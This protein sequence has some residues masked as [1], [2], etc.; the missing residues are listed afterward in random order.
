MSG[1]ESARD[2]RAG[3]VEIQHSK[4]VVALGNSA[5]LDKF[6]SVANTVLAVL[7]AL[8]VHF[9]VLS[10]EIL[11]LGILLRPLDDA[12]KIEILKEQNNLLF[13]I[14]CSLIRKRKYPITYVPA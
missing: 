5:Q 7:N 10:L 6:T 11:V 1:W 4:I 9:G 13:K 14:V 2:K 12:K 8:V 3:V